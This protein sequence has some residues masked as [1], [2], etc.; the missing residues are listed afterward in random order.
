VAADKFQRRLGQFHEKK[1]IL[2]AF[3]LNLR[4]R[5]K[6]GSN[7]SRVRH[8]VSLHQPTIKPGEIEVKSRVL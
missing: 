7:T 1:K 6:R 8:F 5:E 2:G 3:D 4:G